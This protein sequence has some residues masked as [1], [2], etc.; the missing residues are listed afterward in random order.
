MA[1]AE[2]ARLVVGREQRQPLRLGA[3]KVSTGFPRGYKN[4]LHLLSPLGISHY[5]NRAAGILHVLLAWRCGFSTKTRIRGAPAVVVRP[6]RW[7][8]AEA[9]ARAP[10]VPQPSCP[11]EQLRPD[12]QVRRTIGIQ[13]AADRLLHYLMHADIPSGS[14]ISSP[15]SSQNASLFLGPRCRLPCLPP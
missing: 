13:R 11:R 7:S 9:C 6:K 1:H 2:V 15:I 4:C 12:G 14:I 5:C 8:E 10:T 3:I